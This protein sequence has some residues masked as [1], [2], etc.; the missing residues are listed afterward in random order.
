MNQKFQMM[1]K[2]KDQLTSDN[3]SD[4]QMNNFSLYVNSN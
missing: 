3:K 2:Q 4:P 1:G